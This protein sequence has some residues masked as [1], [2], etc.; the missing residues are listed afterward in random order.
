MTA[1][2]LCEVS[3]SH[4]GKETWR[5]GLE[6]GGGA[7]EGF[8]GGADH[9]KDWKPERQLVPGPQKEK[10]PCG[11]APPAPLSPDALQLWD[12][13]CRR[14][15]LCLALEHLHLWCGRGPETASRQGSSG[16]TQGRDQGTTLRWLQVQEE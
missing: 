2:H 6:W 11:E 3:E 9:K 14:V 10:G 15:L 16:L 5:K 12:P 1:R 13:A 7:S 4:E 8:C